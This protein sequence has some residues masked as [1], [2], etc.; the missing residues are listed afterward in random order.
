VDL[1]PAE[2]EVFS[3]SQEILALVG[4]DDSALPILISETM[5]VTLDGTDGVWDGGLG[6][7][8]IKRSQLGSLATYAGTL[9]HEAGHALTGAVD[10]TRFFES[11]LTSYLGATS[12]RALARSVQAG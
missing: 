1:S 3:R 2:A 9:L 6:A 8:V 10:A 7:I 11:V 12:D 5:R 4:A